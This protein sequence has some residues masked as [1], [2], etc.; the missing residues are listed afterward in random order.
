MRK[1]Y[2]IECGTITEKDAL[3]SNQWFTY[4][5]CTNTSCQTKMSFKNEDSSSVTIDK[6]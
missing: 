6:K 4:L 1:K 5:T 3:K 2:C